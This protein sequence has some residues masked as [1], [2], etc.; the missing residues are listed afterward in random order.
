[1]NDILEKREYL[2][3]ITIIEGRNIIGKDSQGTSDPFLKVRVADQVQQSQKKYEQN[4]AVWNQSLTF[5]GV[6]MN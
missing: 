2:V 6:H 3:G 1:M 4:S 5:T